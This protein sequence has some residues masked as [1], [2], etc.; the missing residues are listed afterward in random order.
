[1]INS[2]TLAEVK[3]LSREVAKLASEVEADMKRVDTN[4]ARAQ[5]LSIPPAIAYWP[6]YN[7]K[8]RASLKRRSMD[9]TNAL[10]DL[11]RR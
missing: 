9:L 5:R 10:A 6:G 11:R 8:L 3:R 1:M 7:G 4:A 2:D